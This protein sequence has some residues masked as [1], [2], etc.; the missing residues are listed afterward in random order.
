MITAADGVMDALAAL[1]AATVVFQFVAVAIF[2]IPAAEDV[3]H[4]PIDPIV[5]ALAVVGALL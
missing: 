1:V 5:P 4:V 2:A 3:V